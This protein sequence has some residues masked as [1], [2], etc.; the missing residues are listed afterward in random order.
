[1]IEQ[2]CSAALDG[3]TLQNGEDVDRIGDR[4][5]RRGFMYKAAYKPLPGTLETDENGEPKRLPKW[6]KRLQLCPRQAFDE[7]A[8]YVVHYEGSK[9]WRYVMLG[10]IIAVVLVLCMFPAWPLSLKIGV[11]YT[12]VF[13][14]TF[15]IAIVIARLAVFVVFWFFGVDF[16]VLPNLFD[17]EAGVLDSFRPAH[18][19]ER[20]KDDWFMFAARLFCAVLLAGAVYQLQQTHS[21]SDVGIFAKQSLLDV[22][23]WGHQKLAAVPA[24]KPKYPT[25][26]D[27]EEEH[28]A[29]EGAASE[30]S[31]E[32][33]HDGEEDY[34]CL[35][36]CGYSS[37]D[38]LME[39]CLMSCQCMKELCA[40]PCYKQCSA[41]TRE[42]LNEA[43]KDSCYAEEESKN[44]KV[45]L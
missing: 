2:K 17:E 40:S 29:G 8:Y 14:M 33:P 7:N 9:T 34:S 23:D 20:R 15:I 19:W 42:A 25:L 6:P 24:N 28:Q 26:N 18:S 16:W 36:T 27:I 30:D 31:S 45:E 43:M 5:I 12:S 10:V 22:L 39:D 38:E 4:L 37:Y 44:E 41:T 11:W 32:Q 3:S 13:F 21:V 35:K 1:M